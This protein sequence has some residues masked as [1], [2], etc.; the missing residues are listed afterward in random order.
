MK[1]KFLNNIPYIFWYVGGYCS[2][3]E[4]L[5]TL[6]LEK[7]I[8]FISWKYAFPLF[9]G[10]GV[11]SYIIRVHP[12][13]RFSAKVPNR[14]VTVKLTKGNILKKRNK[15]VI[16]PINN[17]FRVDPSK[18]SPLI[19]S[20]S[21]L[22]QLVKKEFNSEPKELQNLI[23][24]QLR[25]NKTPNNN[26]IYKWGE[27]ISIMGKKK[28]YYL[29]VNTLLNEQNIP[30]CNEEILTTS[31]AKLWEHLSQGA[32]KEDFIIPLVGTG[33][34]RINETREDVFKHILRSFLASLAN[35]NFADSLTICMLRKDIKKCKINFTKQGEFMLQKVTD[36][37][38]SKN[39]SG[40]GSNLLS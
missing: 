27:V 8:D 2:F 3:L 22:S 4:A 30:S 15:S 1:N 23:S 25:E 38:F 36:A 28:K 17:R 40:K 33:R 16:V 13:Q 9:F 32:G 35:T 18:N 21:V 12:K 37:N 7:I 26:G 24:Q 14:D 6:K 31:L 19:E 39:T 5:E 11:V 34:G 29:F 20:N 10:L